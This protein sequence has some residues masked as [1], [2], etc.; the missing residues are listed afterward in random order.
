MANN[1]MIIKNAD[2]SQNKVATIAFDVI[3][4]TDL[5]L[6]EHELTLDDLDGTYQLTYVITPYNS[7]DPVTFDSSDPSVCT[8]SSDGTLTLH[9]IGS[10]TI[11]A[12]SNGISD[13]CSITGVID[14]KN[15]T[16]ARSAYVMS[17]SGTSKYSIAGSFDNTT[18]RNFDIYMLFTD[19]DSTKERLNISYTYAK[20]EGG[21]YV[22]PDSYVQADTA[23]LID[24]NI[25]YAVPI[26]LPENCTRI[27][28]VALNEHYGAQAIFFKSNVRAD[29]SNTSFYYYTAEKAKIAQMS[30]YD[31]VFAKTT[32]AEVPTGYD[33]VCIVW[34]A[35]TANGAVDFHNLTDDQ[36]ANFKLICK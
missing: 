20:E 28:C 16:K 11:T 32:E 36:L 34:K 3:H 18:N 21:V 25:G 14:M 1:A 30:H 2:F 12:T 23:Y 6:D 9:G 5:E 17:P 4:T 26:V 27:V 24:T 19:V 22:L 8:V 7:D 10:A 13:T 29:P 15:I 35:D 33:S 31:Y